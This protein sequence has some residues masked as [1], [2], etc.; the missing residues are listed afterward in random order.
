M[1]NANIMN[2]FS[3]K[4]I[5]EFMKPENKVEFYTSSVDGNPCVSWVSFSRHQNATMVDLARRILRYKKECSK[6]IA[7]LKTKPPEGGF[8]SYLM[9][10]LIALP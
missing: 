7:T 10:F 2:T 1:E 5:L 8:F 3:A 4:I 6:G 9:Y